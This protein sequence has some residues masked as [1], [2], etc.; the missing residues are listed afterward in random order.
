[1][2]LGWEPTPPTAAE[3]KKQR[4]DTEGDE[5]T[6]ADLQHLEAEARVINAAFLLHL[7]DTDMQQIRNTAPIF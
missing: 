4:R 3:R 1:M 5:V 7:S 2:D 6:E